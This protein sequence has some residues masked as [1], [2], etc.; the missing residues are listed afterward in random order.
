MIKGYVLPEIK[1]RR[2]TITIDGNKGEA[3]WNSKA[4]VFIGAYGATRARINTAWDNNMLFLTADIYDEK[5]F[6]ASGSTEN[7]DAIRFF[8]DP[9]NLSLVSPD[10]N[11]FL[12]T[13]TAGGICDFKQGKNGLWCDWTPSGVMSKS[14]KTDRG[15][16]LEVG[17]PWT[18]LKY[19]PQ[20]NKR[21]G[22]HAMVLETSTG[23]SHAYAEPLA[24]NIAEASYSWSP[25]FL[26]D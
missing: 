17:I 11:I 7:D 16:Q 10:E 18:A 24:G 13:V 5:V 2:A 4:P 1:S 21:I 8:L 22:F 23:I 12:I 26:T 15:Y 3:L 19:E 9:K 14:K 20:M 6:S 25:L